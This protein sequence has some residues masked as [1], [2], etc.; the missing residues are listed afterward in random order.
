M[1]TKL[2]TI[3]IILSSS[4]LLSGCIKRVEEIGWGNFNK[5]QQTEQLQEVNQTEEIQATKN[6]SKTPQIG[7]PACDSYLQFISCT[8]AEMDTK[9]AQTIIEE[10]TNDWSQLD[11]ETLTANC[12]SRVKEIQESPQQYTNGLNCS[13]Q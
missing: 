7:I 8:T 5:S 6:N 9:T 4:F 13:I 12:Q 1:K 2:T 11:T 3:T 10:V